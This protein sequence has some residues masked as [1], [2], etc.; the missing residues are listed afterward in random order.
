MSHAGAAMSR[1]QMTGVQK[2]AVLCMSVGP[3]ASAKIFQHLSDEEIEKIT[4][5]IARLRDVGGD[6]SQAVLA[7]F[8]DAAKT[9]RGGVHYARSI[10][11]DVMGDRAGKILDRIQD[12]MLHTGL[13]RLKRAPAELLHSVLRGEHPQA[14]ALIISHLTSDQAST[15]VESMDPEVAGDVLIRVA[16]ME[17][18]AP[19]I[20]RLVETVLSNKTDLSLVDQLTQTGGPEA[21]A[22]LLNQASSTMESEMLGAIAERNMELADEIKNLMFVFEDLKSLDNKSAQRVLREVDSRDLALALKAASD[23]VKG[24]LLKNMSERAAAAL[25]EEME[26]MGPVRVKDVEEA[27]AKI[28]ASVR[29][30]EEAGEIFLASGGGDDFI[31]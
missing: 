1:D 2:A 9:A 26:Y 4:L 12:Q 17:K 8:Q 16:R 22:Q 20:L 3:E 28:I 15:V 29:S 11:R 30:L 18:V 21:V 13:N 7:E 19:D 31:T 10:L 25:L 27:Q 6:T 24:H 23:E 5:E 14:V